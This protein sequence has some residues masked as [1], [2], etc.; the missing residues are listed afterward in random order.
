MF[1]EIDI[2]ISTGMV[3]PDGKL[4]NRGLT[5]CFC[6]AA[7]AHSASIGQSIYTNSGV[8]V[9]WVLMGW[10]I[11]FLRRPAAGDRVKVRTWMRNA[12]RATSDRD[13]IMYD[14]SGEV[15]A[16]ASARWMGIDLERGM[17]VR[18]TP[19]LWEPY[20]PETES[21]ALENPVFIDANRFEGEAVSRTGIKALRCM[22]DGFGHVH[23]TCYL[24]LALEALPEELVNTPFTHIDVAYK[25]Q[26]LPGAAVN[27]DYVPKD[28]RH[29]VVLRDPADDKIHA[30]IALY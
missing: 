25:K 21:F 8:K 23:N 11:E 18:L 12:N 26:I 22:T 5:D 27:L 9:S 10:T 28:G 29:Y 3:S 13:F 6:D 24:D 1:I 2:T 19:E 16:R 15:I 4:T 14:A 30:L 7:N 17:L 20:N